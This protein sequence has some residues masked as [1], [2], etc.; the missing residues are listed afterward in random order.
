[1]RASWPTEVMFALLA[2]G[3][4]DRKLDLVDAHGEQLLEAAILLADFGRSRVEL[5]L[6]VVEIHEDIE[7]VADDGRGLEEGVVRGQAAVCPDL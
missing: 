3:G 1:M 5:D 6:L 7:V 2:V 4:A